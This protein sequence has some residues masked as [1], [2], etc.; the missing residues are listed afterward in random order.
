VWWFGDA[1][2]AR[3]FLEC[4][5]LFVIGFAAAFWSLSRTSRGT[6][7][8]CAALLALCAVYNSVLLV[9]YIAL[10]ISRSRALF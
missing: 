3:S 8:A 9:L 10:L 5:P 7:A 4:Q 2:G 1:F 6:R